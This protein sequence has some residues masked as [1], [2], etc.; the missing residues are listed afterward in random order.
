MLIN[1]IAKRPHKKQQQ[2]CEYQHNSVFWLV[3]VVSRGKQRTR[4]I[5]YVGVGLSIMI[6]KIVA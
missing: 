6:G 4:F 5:N 2:Q 1:Q 3:H